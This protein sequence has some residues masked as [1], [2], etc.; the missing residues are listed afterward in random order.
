MSRSAI[1]LLV[2]ALCFAI[3]AY[4]ESA[5]KVSP[6]GDT[7]ITADTDG[8]PSVAKDQSREKHHAH[9]LTQC[10]HGCAGPK[11]ICHIDDCY[12][13]TKNFYCSMPIPSG[14]YCICQGCVP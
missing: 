12:M 2:I 11:L 5:R 14:E 8:F 1:V 9:A 7:A 4:S 6:H 3:S 10:D 13:T